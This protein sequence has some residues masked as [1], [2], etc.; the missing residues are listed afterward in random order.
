MRKV[1]LISGHYYH[2][3]NR[4][5]DGSRIFFNDKNWRFFLHRW[6][7]YC[8]PEFAETIAYCLMP[9]H[10]HFLIYVKVEEFGRKVMHP[11][12]MSYAKAINKQESRS[13]HLFQGSFQVKLVDTEA[14][15][16][17]L[18][19]YIHLNPVEARYVDH[20][21]EWEYSS[22]LD[23]AGLREGTLTQMNVVLE[24]FSDHAKYIEFVEEGVGDIRPI[25]GWLLD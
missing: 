3:Y 10:Y 11:F 6:R 9:T 8:L 19:R 14:Y 22:Y 21:A 18:T 5:V 15:L 20:P 23:Y 1:K 16:S 2:I 13:G 17:H 4:G 12:V 7:K 25:A 24:S